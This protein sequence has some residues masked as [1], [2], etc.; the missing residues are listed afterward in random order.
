MFCV[1]S[2]DALKILVKPYNL[3]VFFVEFVPADPLEFTD[4]TGA[5]KRFLNQF[6]QWCDISPEM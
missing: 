2:E 6:A 3:R 4:D 5:L 1:L